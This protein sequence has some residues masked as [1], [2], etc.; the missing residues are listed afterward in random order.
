MTDLH[1]TDDML[2]RLRDGSLTQQE[3]IGALNHI[4][5]CTACAERFASLYAPDA[6]APPDLAED[7]AS[8]IAKRPAPM[9]ERTPRRRFKFGYGMRDGLAACAAVVILIGSAFL[10]P[11]EVRAPQAPDGDGVNRIA[12]SMHAFSQKILLKLEV[13][14]N[15]QEKR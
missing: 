6:M 12:A 10:D 7:I 5:E 4:G 14:R 9:I 2:A 1:V 3:C 8:R 13:G 11:G 15:D